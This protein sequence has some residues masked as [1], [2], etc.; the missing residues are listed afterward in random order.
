MDPAL[1]ALIIEAGGELA[2]LLLEAFV[3][4]NADMLSK[5]VRDILPVTLATT[6]AKRAADA[7]AEAKFGS[8]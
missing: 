8:K 6:L 4:G 5:P 7:A 1:V 3:S 2:K